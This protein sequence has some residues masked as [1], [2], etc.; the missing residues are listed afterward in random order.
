[1]VCVYFSYG[2]FVAHANVIVLEYKGNQNYSQNR[3][4]KRKES[5]WCKK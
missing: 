2:N 4:Q 1:M 5:Y 3:I